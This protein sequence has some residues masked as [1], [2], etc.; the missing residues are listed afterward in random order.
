MPVTARKNTPEP[1]VQPPDTYDILGLSFAEAALIRDL[2]SKVNLG[3]C[4]NSSPLFDAL[5]DI[6]A[7]DEPAYR[8]SSDGF[9][10]ESIVPLDIIYVNPRA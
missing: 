2:I 8:F 10:D 4:V 6:L 7:G 1:V 5:S 9:L 3:A